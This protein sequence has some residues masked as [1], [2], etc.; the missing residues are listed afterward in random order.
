MVS[1]ASTAFGMSLSRSKP[2]PAEQLASARTSAAEGREAMMAVSVY[3]IRWV[4]CTPSATTI[5][6][7]LYLSSC[8]SGFGRQDSSSSDSS[9]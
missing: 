1:N 3:V 7:R 8:V 2:T 5:A 4:E 9:S 6:L